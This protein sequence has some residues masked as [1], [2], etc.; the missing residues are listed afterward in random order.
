MLRAKLGN[1]AVR[2]EVKANDQY[3]R[4]ARAS[5]APDTDSCLPH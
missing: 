4:K 3:N 1:A 2:C 5:H